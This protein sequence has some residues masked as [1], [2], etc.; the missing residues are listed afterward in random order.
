MAQELVCK[1]HNILF[2]PS[3][4]DLSRHQQIEAPVLSPRASASYTPLQD[5][6][7]RFLLKNFLNADDYEFQFKKYAAS[8]VY[9]LAYGL[10]VE[11]GKEW[12]LQASHQNLEHLVLA[13]EMGR[14]MVD[15]LP[16][17]NYLPG[18]LAP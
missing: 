5:I 15:S 6:E 10:R 16:F 13:G 7:S 17:L 11:T 1:D 9:T 12:Q 2:R 4:A 14:W 8:I 18:F 3:G